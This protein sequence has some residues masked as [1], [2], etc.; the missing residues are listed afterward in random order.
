MIEQASIEIS[1]EIGHAVMPLRTFLALGRG[2]VMTIQT[3]PE[4]DVVL[5]ASGQPIAAGQV[6]VDDG[7]ISI[8]ILDT[9][10]RG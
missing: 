6:L 5:R 7:R 1:F 3:D 10:K 9:R 2:A 8:A 4:A